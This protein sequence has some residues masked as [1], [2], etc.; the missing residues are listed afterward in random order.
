MGMPK[1]ISSLLKKRV[2][3]SAS[4]E[5]ALIHV[6]RKTFVHS[7]HKDLAYDDT[8]LPIGAGQT[9]SQPYTVVFMLEKLRAKSGD[10]IMEVGYGSGWQTALLADI[11]GNKGK[12]Y[13]IEIIPALCEVGK[14]NLEKLPELRGCIEL[15]CQ[16]AQTGLPEIAK[17]IGGFDGIIAAAEVKEV[18]AAWRDELRVGGRL[19][20]PKSESLFLEIKIR[21]G[22]FSIQE[23]P[24]FMFVPFV[25]KF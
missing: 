5:R 15:F 4:I 9:I 8:A 13:A 21:E 20:Y 19:V 24:G 10:R 12:V 18:P 14:Q 22:A 11:V 3:K 6:D 1:L 16:N 23:F 7:T 2:L 25:E 17:R